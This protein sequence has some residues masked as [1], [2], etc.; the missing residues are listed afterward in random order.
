MY[1]IL[2]R[3]FFV[4]CYVHEI[5]ITERSI[6]LCDVQSTT[7]EELENLVMNLLKENILKVED[8]HGQGYDLAANMSRRHKGLQPRRQKK[9]EKLLYVFCHDH[10]LNLLLVDSA[11]S[12][13]HIVRGFFFT[14]IE[15]LYTFIANSMKWH[16][17]FVQTQQALNPD[18]RTAEL[19]K[20]SDT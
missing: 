8:I 12:R 2:H 17:V 13:I 10:F 14:V 15:K 20:L 4:V 1:H 18:Q 3:C 11:K 5:T 19:Q 7:G 6:H 9:K 16:G